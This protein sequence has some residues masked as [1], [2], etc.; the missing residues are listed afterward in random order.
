MMSVVNNLIDFMHLKGTTDDDFEEDVF[1]ENDD[2]SNDYDSVGSFDFD[3][4]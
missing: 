2:F 1:E 4:P 3:E